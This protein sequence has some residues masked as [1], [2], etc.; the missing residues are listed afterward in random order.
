MRVVV[1]G[2]PVSTRRSASSSSAIVPVPVA[3]PAARV[4]F[5]GALRVTTTVSCRSSAASPMTETSIV[6]VVVP[7]A[8]VSIPAGRAV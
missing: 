2:P 6:R 1:P 4:A 7:G 5:T 3:A 8:K